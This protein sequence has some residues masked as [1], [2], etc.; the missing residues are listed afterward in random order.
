VRLKVKAEIF[1]RAFIDKLN[2]HTVQN[3]PNTNNHPIS[4]TVGII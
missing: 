3:K 4:E 2:A 1:F